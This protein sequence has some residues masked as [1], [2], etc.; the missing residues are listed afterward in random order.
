MNYYDVLGVPKTASPEDIKRAYRKLASQHH[1]DKGGDT[2]KFQQVEEAYRMLSDPA[3]KSEYD[4][5][6]PFGQPQ[7]NWSQSG[8]GPFDQFFHQFG[9]DLGSL[10][11]ARRGAP[12]NRNINLST[13]IT[14]EEAFFGKDVVAQYNIFNGHRRTFEARIPP[15]VE[16]G[17]T[18]RVPGAGDHS[19]PQL[20]PG[21]ALLAINIIPHA[22]FNRS[23]A[24]LA[25]ELEISVWE[26]MLGCE[27]DIRTIDNRVVTIKIKEGTQPNTTMRLQGYGMVIINS[28]SRGN[29][30][31]NVKVK[32][33]NGLTEYQKNTIK[34]FLS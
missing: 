3:K 33:P 5:P 27:K 28:H 18:L 31:I 15:G 16:G 20:P 22:R 25:E 24:D 17:N 30:L 32:I 14:L 13:D 19:V 10:F 29:H 7:S 4:N 9:P 11:G 6:N 21:D 2:A 8:G 26:A 12:K 1:P 34:S 23:G